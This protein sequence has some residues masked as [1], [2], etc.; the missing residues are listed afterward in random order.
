MKHRIR[1]LTLIV[2]LCSLLTT[3]VPPVRAVGFRDV[4][5]DFWASTSIRRAVDKGLFQGETADRFGVG[6][7]MSRGAFAV[8][9]CRLFQWDM[10]KPDRGSFTDN[11]NKNA[12]YYSAVETAFKHDAVTGI[13]RT[14][15][16]NDPITREELA[17][18]LV[19]ALGYTPIAGLWNENSLSFQD[20]TLNRSYLTMAVTLGI[21][22]GLTPKTFAPDRAA[23]RE[24]VAVML[25]RVYERLHA[26]TN[27]RLG[28]MQTQADA[29]VTEKLDAA[30]VAGISVG[31]DGQIDVLTTMSRT[32][33]NN[34]R[35]KLQSGGETEA[36]LWVKGRTAVLNGDIDAAADAVAETVKSGK[37][38]G[39][40]ID[41]PALR[42]TR[43]KQYTA[44]V[45]RLNAQLGERSLWVTTTAPCAE[46]QTEN[47]YDFAALAQQAEHIVLRFPVDET[48][49]N[50]FVTA[51]AEPLEDIYRALTRLKG[52]IAPEKLVLQL[53]VSGSAWKN[54]SHS[55]TLSAA[56]V[57][58]LLGAQDVRHYHSDRYASCYL[59]RQVKDTMLTV[60]YN[61]TSCLQA[62]QQLAAFFG[63]S[64][65]CF[66]RLDGVVASSAS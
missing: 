36:L 44:F 47:S 43:R 22:K 55:T 38:D 63:V 60:W 46:Q 56:E 9:L 15:R 6:H 40:F 23:K 19:R 13:S 20:V 17:V 62:K 24:E 14:Y 30:A 61:D 34:I 48:V 4:P 33:R 57:T 66:D 42:T 39:V 35:K 21:V 32:E 7:A 25:M 2:L 37:W 45:R 54:G 10:V 64:G 31:Y 18:M 28:L 59:L 12:W 50:S 49:K 52:V 1:Q 8:V 41:F 58:N 5:H 3:I 51:P 27:P 26:E 16:P 65:V 53:T 29:D 11:Q